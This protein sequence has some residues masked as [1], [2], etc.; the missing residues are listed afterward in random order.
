[1]DQPNPAPKEEPSLAAG[2]ALIFVGLLVF[3]PSGLCTGFITGAAI[4]NNEWTGLIVPLL[5][6]GPFVVGG[7]V[8]LW[9][10]VRHFVRYAR[11]SKEN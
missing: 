11:K 6:G 1:M 7:A 10:G 3:V 5:L 8:M 9:Q 4:A 2:C